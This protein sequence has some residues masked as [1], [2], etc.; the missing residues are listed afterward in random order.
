[1]RA[2]DLPLLAALYIG[3]VGRIIL[4]DFR[5]LRGD[6]LFGKRTFLVRHGRV[7]TC[8][9]SALCWVAAAVLLVSTR[10]GVTPAYVLTTAA[11]TAGALVLLRDLARDRGHRR[12]EWAISAL[13]IVGRGLVLVL[14]VDLAAPAAGW[15]AQL[16]ATVIVALA[17]VLGRQAARMRRHGPTRGMAAAP[18]PVPAC[19]LTANTA[20]SGDFPRGPGR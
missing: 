7:W 4:K 12:D 11:G 2:G 1:M 19:A 6:A 10:P 18:G 20:G 15:P 3:F 8:R 13:A 14:A 9:V 17:S 16:T 5:D